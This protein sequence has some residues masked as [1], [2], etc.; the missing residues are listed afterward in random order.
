MSNLYLK[1]VEQNA[2]GD[3]SMEQIDANRRR[4][5]TAIHETPIVDNLTECIREYFNIGAT[6]NKAF[7]QIRVE[8]D[9]KRAAIKEPAEF[10]QKVLSKAVEK[11]ATKLFDQMVQLM[12]GTVPYDKDTMKATLEMLDKTSKIAKALSLPNAIENANGKVPENF[13]GANYK[14]TILKV[15]NKINEQNL[16]KQVEPAKGVK[17]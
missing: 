7:Q 5:L 3:Q 11:T 4:I 1:T 6:D 9:A 2:L 17:F 8:L 12:D 14:E 10:N 15:Q 16:K 13:R